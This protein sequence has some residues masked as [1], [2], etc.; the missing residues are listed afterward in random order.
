MVCHRKT[1]N[2]PQLSQH[3]VSKKGNAHGT[4]SGVNMPQKRHTKTVDFF[5]INV[6]FKFFSLKHVDIKGRK[7]T[8]FKNPRNI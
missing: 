3:T 5:Y 8:W 1:H 7:V 4:A 6:D 2:F